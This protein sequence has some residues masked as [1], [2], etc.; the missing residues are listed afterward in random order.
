MVSQ[1]YSSTVIPL[2]KKQRDLPTLQIQTPICPLSLAL[3]HPSE[4][5][6]SL[7][8]PLSLRQNR[9]CLSFISSLLYA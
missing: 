7:G 5:M 1:S 9:I 8:V 6:P 3:Y 2:F 4:M